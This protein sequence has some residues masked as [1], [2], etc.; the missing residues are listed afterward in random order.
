MDLIREARLGGAAVLISTH[1]LDLA[2]QACEEAV[3]LR[4]G[5]VVGASPA[6]ELSGA[7]GAARYRSMLS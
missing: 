2:V 5:E 3:V 1:L 7:E 4:Q 6:A